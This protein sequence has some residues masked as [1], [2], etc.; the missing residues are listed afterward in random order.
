MNGFW[1]KSEY[2]L[3][4][5][6][7]GRE[8]FP[9]GLEDVYPFEGLFGCQQILLVVGTGTHEVVEDADVVVEVDVGEQV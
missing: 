9:T 4:Q 7:T 2:R 1:K 3:L 8:M 5:V 6:N